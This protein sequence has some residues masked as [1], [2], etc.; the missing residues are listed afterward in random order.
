MMK[1]IFFCLVILK[2][3]QNYN[4]KSF[5]LSPTKIEGNTNKVLNYSY[6]YK[7]QIILAESQRTYCFSKF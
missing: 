3:L 2:D 7:N 6:F 5:F 1:N 4:R